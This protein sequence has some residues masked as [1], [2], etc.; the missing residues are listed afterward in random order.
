MKEFAKKVTLSLLSLVLGLTLIV[1]LSPKAEAT[2]QVN[3]D[4]NSRKPISESIETRYYIEPIYRSVIGE[5]EFKAEIDKIRDAAKPAAT[6]EANVSRYTTISKAA[7]YLKGQ[8]KSRVETVSFIIPEDLYYDYGDTIGLIIETAEAH[9]DSCTG[10]EGDAL[11]WGKIGYSWSGSWIYNEDT[12]DYDLQ[13]DITFKWTTTAAQ[14]SSL[15]TKV[16]SAI[17]S[18]SLSGKTEEQKIKAIHDYICSNVDYDYDHLDQGSNYP[19][20]FSAYAALCQ[21]TAVCQGYAILFYRMAKEAGLGV[22][23]ITSYDHAWN[24]VR[25]GSVYYNIDTTWDGGDSSTYY[26]YYMKGMRDF[27]QYDHI[28]E[29]PYNTYEFEQNYPMVKDS[30]MNLANLSQSY[31]TVNDT[32]VTT[33][34]SGKPKLIVFGGCNPEYESS[35]SAFLTD[36]F[37]YNVS[38]LDVMVVD[39][40]S[41]TKD[42]VKEFIKKVGGNAGTFC[43]DP[44]N[45]NTSK[46][47]SYMDHMDYPDSTYAL[48]NMVF[49]DSSNKIQHYWNCWMDEGMTKS[50]VSYYLGLTLSFD[51]P[52]IAKQPVS[53]TVSANDIAYFTVEA[54]GH[55]DLSYQWYYRTS[56][57][58]SWA[59]STMDGALTDTLPVEAVI[60]RNGYQYCCEVKNAYGSKYTNTVTLKVKPNITSQPTSVSVTEGQ[61]A[62]FTVKAQGATSYQWYY[63]T[64]S[65]GTWAKSTTMTGATTATLSV[66]AV[67]ARNGYQ[68]RCCVTNSAGSVY[69]NA[70]TL[71][72]KSSSKPV[73]TTQPKSVSVANGTTVKFT[74]AATKAQKYQ[75]Y[76]RTSSSG[77]WAKSSTT[78]ATTNTLTVEAITARNGYQ[79]RCIISNDVGSTTSNTATLTVQ[80][81]GKPVITAHPA[82]VTATAGTTATFTVKAAGA[83]SYQWY[84]RTSS[85]GTWA[86]SSTTGATTA[87]LSVDAETKRNGYQ[88]RCTVTNS[89]GS[90]TSNAA[91]LTVTTIVKPTITTQPKSVT[92]KNGQTVKFT[93]GASGTSLK[94][95]WYYRT[96]STGTWAKSTMT[97]ATTKTLTVEAVVGRNGYQYRCQVSNSAGSVYT[98][99]ATLT[100]TGPKYRALL[101]GEVNFS[102]ETANRNRGDVQLLNNMLQ[103]VTGPT[104]GKYT[105]TCEYDLTNDGIQNAISTAFAGADEG[106]VSLFFI[107]THGVVDVETGPYA[108]ELVTYGGNGYDDY[109]TLGELATWLKAVPGKVIVLLGSCGSGAAIVENGTVRYRAST[110]EDDLDLFNDAVIQAFREADEEAMGRGDVQPQTGEFRNSKFYVMTAAAHQES[111]WGQEGSNSYNFFPYYFAKGAGT[112]KPADANGN[113]VITMLEMFNYVYT[114]ALG[115]YNG[116]EYQHAQM[117]PANSTYELFK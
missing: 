7:S 23:V 4:K 73:I 96:S 24:I 34:A 110:S 17:S 55:G 76:Y 2:N 115:P 25:K 19:L 13:I 106:D 100:V 80:V 16:N 21:G 104:G 1:S 91:T 83:T 111:S 92:V 97:G 113:G 84:Y 103:S 72:V 66:P 89:Y 8:M 26:T 105:V 67:T 112:G 61:T 107:A 65:S 18:L 40:D 57:S 20:Q 69:S 78:G 60:G 33:A 3:P 116:T 81:S 35:T 44:N 71:T 11:K 39:V 5:E 54:L 14:E 36:L 28:R 95:Q 48:P 99:A 9:T 47:F 90:V 98:N 45:Q 75:W 93:V 82:S 59:K 37:S 94:Y 117:Y 43:L 79:Y 32:G 74:V 63:R 6:E 41:H 42:E 102:W 64:S 109:L 62:T 53:V 22:R 12:Y 56:S 77:T 10:Q 30:K 108:G 27:F 50:M 85:T 70:A 51:K 101:V 15:T 52:R 86:K 58:G 114:N 31:T 88:Y 29:N 46:W 38:G 68:Y 87:T 49:I